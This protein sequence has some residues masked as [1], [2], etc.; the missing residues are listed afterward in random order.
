MGMTLEDGDGCVDKWGTFPVAWAQEF[1]VGVADPPGCITAPFPSGCIATLDSCVAVEGV[2]FGGNSVSASP[3]EFEE[4]PVVRGSV[5]TGML[6]IGGLNISSRYA[7][8]KGRR[9]MEK[10]F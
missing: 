3:R 1:V 5:V 8:M 4:R 10:C 2:T 6:E 9:P 7:K